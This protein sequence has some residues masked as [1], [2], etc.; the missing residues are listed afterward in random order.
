MGDILLQ[1]GPLTGSAV[2]CGGIQG[3]PNNTCQ[4]LQRVG[5]ADVGREVGHESPDTAATSCAQLH[6][7]GQAWVSDFEKCSCLHVYA[8]IKM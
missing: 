4:T 5:L 2:V 8:I 3:P 7:L 1:S 6:W